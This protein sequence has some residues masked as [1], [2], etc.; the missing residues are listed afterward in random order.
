M[1]A[2]ADVSLETDVLVLG[3][4]IAGLTAA[5]AASELVEEVCVVSP[6]RMG[7][8]S[9]TAMSTG[10]VAVCDWE[11][12]AS[13]AQFMEDTLSS[14]QQLSNPELVEVLAR[15]AGDAL[16]RLLEGGARFETRDGALK[17]TLIAEHHGARNYHA[18]Y[19][20]GTS[21]TV[22]IA[23]GLDRANGKV[24]ALDYH[25][26]EGLIVDSSTGSVIGARL[27]DIQ[28]NRVVSVRAP[29]VVLATGGCGQLF[30]LTSNPIDICGS[31]YSAALRAGAVLRDMEFIQFYPYRCVDPFSRSRVAI[32]PST[33]PVGGRLFNAEGKR[34]MEQ[35]DPARLEATTRDVAARSIYM[36][37]LSGRGVGEGVRL[38]LS[39]VSRSSLEETNYRV[40]RAIDKLGIDH[41]SYRFIIRPEAHYFMGGVEIDESAR[42]S[43]IG[44][45]AAG[46]TAG[47]LH[48]ANR[49]TNNSIADAAV[50]G[51][52]AGNSA[53]MHA[54]EIPRK[55]LRALPAETCAPTPN[56]RRGQRTAQVSENDVHDLAWSDLGIV[57][58]GDGLRSGLDNVALLNEKHR[59]DRNKYDEDRPS[60]IRIQH[61]L[62]TASIALFAAFDR[63]ESRGAHF[64]SDFPETDPAAA[65]SLRV[66]RGCADDRGNI[67]VCRAAGVELMH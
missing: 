25:L 3:S 16:S 15:E 17:T 39:K 14:G 8:D 5:R 6:K 26:V 41:A 49:L 52:R 65:K 60:W 58:S 29:S 46:E 62:D 9:S 56:A 59:S 61:L 12:E 64:R 54:R 30:P 7:R 37:M 55:R 18:L 34:F 22:P 35:Y 48:G 66:L 10:G 44:L 57:R 38:D 42:T 2:D 40:V 53:G 19:S 67:E 50:F 27:L 4:G 43:L 51:H 28:H 24:R 45:F 1:D 63:R 11:S 33:F 23:E 21:Y 32:Q 47:G 20:M 31:G 13:V 36:E